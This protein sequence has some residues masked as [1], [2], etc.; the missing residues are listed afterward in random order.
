MQGCWCRCPHG[1]RIFAR[2]AGGGGRICARVTAG[3]GLGMGVLMQVL[4]WGCPHTWS[5]QKRSSHLRCLFFQ[6]HTRKPL[7]STQNSD[8]IWPTSSVQS[9]TWC[10]L[11]GVCVGV[12]FS[13][14][15]RR[16]NG[17]QRPFETN[18]SESQRCPRFGRLFSQKGGLQ[19]ETHGSIESSIHQ[20]L[21]T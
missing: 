18:T 5:K 16:A 10:L 12:F 7:N 9:S 14:L 3:V 15:K 2:L 4:L 8:T 19:T 6:F 1:W 11:S 17:K 20:N 13:L 21:D